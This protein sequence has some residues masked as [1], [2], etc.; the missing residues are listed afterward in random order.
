MSA[1]TPYQKLI[2]DIKTLLSNNIQNL[3]VYD[4]WPGEKI[5]LPA[6]ILYTFATRENTVWFNRTSRILEVGIT[7]DVWAGKPSLRD[8]YAD[9]IIKVLYENMSSFC[10][11]IRLVSSRDLVEYARRGAFYRKALDFM[12]LV[13]AP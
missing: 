11:G 10:L 12:C 5:K 8:T 1:T 13:I 4:E 9:Q 7:V 3:H 6:A 2:S